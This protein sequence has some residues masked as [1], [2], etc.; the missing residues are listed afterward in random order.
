MGRL[1]DFKRHDYFIFAENE[2]KQVIARPYI[3]QR[4]V[5]RVSPEKFFR[6]IET[7]SSTRFRKTFSSTIPITKIIRLTRLRQAAI[8]TTII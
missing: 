1:R 3:K 2:R 5:I 8:Q 6:L 4:E 7:S